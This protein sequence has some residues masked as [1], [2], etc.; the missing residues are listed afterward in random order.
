MLLIGPMLPI[1]DSAASP[2]SES[3]S[4]IIG[5]ADADARQPYSPTGGVVAATGPVLG[6][7]RLDL[8]PNATTECTTCD[9]DGWMWTL[10]PNV[11]H[12]RWMWRWPTMV[13]GGR[14]TVG[15]VLLVGMVPSVLDARN[16]VLDGTSGAGAGRCWW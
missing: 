3:V 6:R 8:V 7:L 14:Q 10:V 11:I 2:Y 4:A 1:A 15:T 13:L 9:M 16:T 5:P 12:V